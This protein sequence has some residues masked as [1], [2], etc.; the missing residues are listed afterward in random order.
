MPAKKSLHF[1]HQTWGLTRHPH[2]HPLSFDYIKDELGAP[3]STFPHSCFMVAGTQA[4]SAKQN[5]VAF[6]RLANLGQGRCVSYEGCEST[7]VHVCM[8]SCC[9]CMCVYGWA[10][11]WGVSAC[12]CMHEV[13]LIHTH[14]C[15]PTHAHRDTHIHTHTHI[16][17]RAHHTQ[18][19]QIHAHVP[20]G[21]GKKPKRRKRMRVM[22]TACQT[23]V[24]TV[25]RTRKSGTSTVPRACTAGDC[26]CASTFAHSHAHACSVICNCSHTWRAFMRIIVLQVH[27]MNL[28]LWQA[29]WI[30]L[31]S[32]TVAKSSVR[33]KHHVC[34]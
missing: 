14:T 33:N 32:C 1:K 22:M 17:A 21:T 7:H 27:G 13:T 29:M 10:V 4:T 8:K 9:A 5:Y 26:D 19:T 6:L 18:H 25:R 34:F 30:R 11:G 20:V 12:V 15:T 24:G 31:H 2:L 3:R 28:R 23:A 16:H